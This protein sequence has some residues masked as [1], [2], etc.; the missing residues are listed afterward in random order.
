VSL[1]KLTNTTGYKWDVA[2]VDI[3]SA[4]SEIGPSSG[5]RSPAWRSHCE[6]LTSPLS[7]SCNSLFR[8]KFL[9]VKGSQGACGLGEYF[10]ILCSCSPTGLN[11]VGN[12]FAA[13]TKT[14]RNIF[15]QMLWIFN[16]V[17]PCSFWLVF[18]GY[19]FDSR[20]VW[21]YYIWYYFDTS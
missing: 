19:G 9:C 18:R 7:Y 5:A 20:G 12:S 10:I 8:F 11:T 2:W 21:S 1:N 15:L 17:V 16:Y 6:R 13:T 14:H 4:A 3:C